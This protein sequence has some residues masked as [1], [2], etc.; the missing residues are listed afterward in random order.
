VVFTADGIASDRRARSSNA[1]GRRC[2]PL[3]PSLLD[4][5]RRFVEGQGEAGRID[6]GRLCVWAWLDPQVGSVRTM[7][8][9]TSWTR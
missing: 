7:M 2:G 6:Q 5:S 9:S 4:P 1:G 3:A 8:L